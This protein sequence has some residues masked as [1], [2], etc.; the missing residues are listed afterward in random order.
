MSTCRQPAGAQRRR[1]VVEVVYLGRDNPIAIQ[2]SEDGQV[3]DLSGITRMTLE[4]A[5]HGV[6]VD[7]AEN[8]SGI[9]WEG[10]DGV[11]RMNLGDAEV[12]PGVYAATI[13]AYDPL[14]PDGQVLVHPCGASL[15][16]RFVSEE[17]PESGQC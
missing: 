15:T 4:V 9:I 2:L 10:P 5:G 1:T 16:L 12:P 11:I 17:L 7:S 8:S 6:V 3:L 13:V 14:H